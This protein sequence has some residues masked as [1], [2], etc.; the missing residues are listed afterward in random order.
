MC[1]HRLNS[2]LGGGAGIPGWRER[3]PAASCILGIP[4]G[5]R[6]GVGAGCRPRA[7]RTV[8]KHCW[9]VARRAVTQARVVTP[10]QAVCS[11]QHPVQEA[12]SRG[13]GPG[14][15][16]SFLQARLDSGSCWG[17]GG[18]PGSPPSRFW[19]PEA[20]HQ[21]TQQTVTTGLALQGKG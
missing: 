21:V 6:A 2:A 17:L 13:P 9:A 4:S 10:L 15:H 3:G 19:E 20:H 8:Y 18:N 7:K 11:A 12:A 5:S 16:S 1:T 14:F